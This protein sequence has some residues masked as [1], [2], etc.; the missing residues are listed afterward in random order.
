MISLAQFIRVR[1]KQELTGLQA[2]DG[3]VLSLGLIALGHNRGDSVHGDG[4]RRIIETSQNSMVLGITNEQ[5]ALLI[6]DMVAE[7]Q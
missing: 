1:G 2:I 4:Q 7:K 3:L 5:Q 6:P